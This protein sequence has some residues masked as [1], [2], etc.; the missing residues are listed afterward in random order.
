MAQDLVMG[1]S[2]F[3]DRSHIQAQARLQLFGG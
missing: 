2:V 1:E 3:L